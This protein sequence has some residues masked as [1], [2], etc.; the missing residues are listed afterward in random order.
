MGM[1]K[2]S[3]NQ[4]INEDSSF[5]PDKPEGDDSANQGLEL[6]RA[7]RIWQVVASIPHGRVASYGQIAALA[8]L[9]G[10]ARFVGTTLGKLPRG[11]TL[12]WHRVVNASLQIAPR[13]SQRMLEQKRRLRDEGVIFK[14]NRVVS[15]FR[16]E[17]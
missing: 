15:T 1:A 6:S 11:T 12:P 8:G 4:G 10:Y 16:L 14:G 2:K 5:A 9:P 13:N 7:E 3:N 17:P